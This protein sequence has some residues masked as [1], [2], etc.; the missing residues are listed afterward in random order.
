MP[1]LR[2]T[3]Q[4][5]E[6]E[7]PQAAGGQRLDPIAHGSRVKRDRRMPPIQRPGRSAA[8]DASTEPF[9][10]TMRALAAVEG[11]HVLVI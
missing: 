11:R 9:R 5:G 10:Y 3:V 4:A 8:A 2:G 1:A 6:G 7:H